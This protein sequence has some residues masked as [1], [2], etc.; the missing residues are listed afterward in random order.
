MDEFTPHV[1]LQE[2]LSSSDF[3]HFVY[4]VDLFQ[5]RLKEEFFRTQR[6]NK[7]FVFIKIFIKP[8]E[9]FGDWNKNVKA[10][11]AWKIST[12]TMLA[13]LDFIDVIGFLPGG[14]IGL[15]FLD[16]DI[17]KLQEIRKKILR[18]LSE[19]KTFDILRFKNRRGPIFEAFIHN[20]KVKDNAPEEDKAIKKFNKESKPFFTLSRLLYTENILPRTKTRALQMFVKRAIDIGCTGG[21]LIVLSPILLAIAAIVKFS[22]PKGP[23]IFK[24]TRVGQH[25]KLFT[26]Y[27]FR[28]MYVDAEE[29]KKALEHLNET[30]GP[31]FKMKNDPR[32]YP[33][34]RILRKFSLDELP[35]LFN[36]L[37][38]DMSIVG[39]RPPIPAETATYSPWHNMRLAV[40]PGLTCIWQVS[41]R[42]NISFEDWMRLDNQYIQQASIKNDISLIA[43]TFKVVFKGEGAY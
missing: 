8:F 37:R 5:L 36:I 9:I 26:M 30:S 24:Q 6:N 32:I 16:T 29:R 3:N 34:G 43:K 17:N 2:I 15:I 39:P 27:K 20:G 1:S 18:N 40:K 13:E 42:S 23:V 28:S 38:G 31:T 7:P 10:I 21:A 14:G 22:D 25:G 41:G 35:Q 12:L 19:S 33:M 4:P 11:R